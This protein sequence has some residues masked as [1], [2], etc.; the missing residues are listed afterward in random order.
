MTDVAAIENRARLTR[1]TCGWGRPE[2][3]KDVVRRYWRDVHSPAISRRAGVYTYRHTPFD[4]VRGDLFQPLAGVELNAPQDAQLQ[5]MSDVAYL[6]LA[7]LEAFTNSPSSAHVKSQLLG[8]I[9]IIVLRSTTYK[10]VGDNLRTYLDRTGDPTPQ[11]PPPSPR[12]GV[13]FRQQ[14]P[15]PAFR[16]SIHELARRW[17]QASGVLR[18]RVN[19]YD[20]PDMEAERSAGYPVKTHPEEQQYQAYLDL[21]VESEAAAGPLL[22]LAGDGLAETLAAVHAYPVPMIYTFVWEGRPTL[23]GL[24]GYPAYEAIS[25]F[26][27]ENQKDPELLAWMYGAVVA[28][29][30]PEE[31][32]VG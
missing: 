19:V 12:F 23:V 29:A 28:G 22:R 14:G 25:A 31:P 9:E 13:F 8:D 3:P 20:R 7:G 2:L 24:R 32:G 18:V 26:G 21:V 6:D 30:S 15:E 4:A 27:A 16:T 11:G 17:G 5:W 1:T 10:A